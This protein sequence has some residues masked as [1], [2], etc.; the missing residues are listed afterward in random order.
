MLLGRT[1]LWMLKSPFTKYATNG[2][3]GEIVAAA[4]IQ[5]MVSK[6]QDV[7]TNVYTPVKG[8]GLYTNDLNANCIIVTI[9]VGG[10]LY[11]IPDK[12]IENLYD[13]NQAFRHHYITVK[14]GLLPVKY[15]MS[16]I[17]KDV[18]DVI[19]GVTGLPIKPRDVYVGVSDKGAQ[20]LT[21]EEATYENMKRLAKTEDNES[22][23]SKLKNALKDKD[24]LEGKFEQVSEAYAKAMKYI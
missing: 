9:D 4:F 12:Y 19:A 1:G 13:G 6:G 11:M 5:T 18:S 8:E 16:E 7:K 3:T 14:V 22:T 23:M 15:D 24:E 17:A 21:D 20:I 2:L 10:K